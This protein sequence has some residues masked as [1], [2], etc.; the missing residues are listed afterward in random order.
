ML[1]S[2]RNSRMGHGWLTTLMYAISARF[3]K[4]MTLRNCVYTCA[5][6][7]RDDKRLPANHMLITCCKQS[8]QEVPVSPCSFRLPATKGWV[9]AW[10]QGQKAGCMGA[11]ERGQKAGWGPGNE[12]KRLGG[13]PGNEVKRLGGGLGTRSK[14]WVGAWE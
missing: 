7:S 11:W 1:H 5:V 12:V 4:S 2:S 8:K 3:F 13:G 9:G 14:G 10:E 6:E